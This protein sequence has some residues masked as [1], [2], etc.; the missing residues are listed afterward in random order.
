MKK[1]SISLF[2]GLMLAA[3]GVQAG[4]LGGGLG[5]AALGGNANG[6]VTVGTITNSNVDATANATGKDSEAMA[7]GVISA[8]PK[9]QQGVNAKITVGVIDNSTIRAKATA[10]DGGAAYAGGVI[11]K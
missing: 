4:G 7:G 5:A 6:T 8:T 3:T 9:G 2:L 11:S 1:R 10:K